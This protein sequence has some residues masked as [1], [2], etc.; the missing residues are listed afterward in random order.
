M[1]TTVR[2]RIETALGCTFSRFD[3]MPSGTRYLAMITYELM[4]GDSLTW[5][6]EIAGVQP[7]DLDHLYRR[8]VAF[9][10]PLLSGL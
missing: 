6:T 7:D 4:N 2:T 10:G 3:V 5:R 9:W 1:I 8:A